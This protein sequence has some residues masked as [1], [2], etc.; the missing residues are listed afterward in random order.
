MS[1]ESK[2]DHTLDLFLP[3]SAHDRVDCLLC[4]HRLAAQKI[5]IIKFLRAN[6]GRHTDEIAY[7]C[8]VGDPCRRIRELNLEV[9]WQ[10]GLVIRGRPAPITRRNKFGEHRA[11]HSWTVGRIEDA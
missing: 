7:A 5:R 4:H 6:P 3:E 11:M 9:L 10:F 8:A 1:L 2:V